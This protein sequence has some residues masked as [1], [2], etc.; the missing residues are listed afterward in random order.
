MR[1]PA[2]QIVNWMPDICVRDTWQKRP[3]QNALECASI[4]KHSS[5]GLTTATAGEI[6]KCSEGSLFDF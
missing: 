5:E 6:F 1:N 3:T 2:N 4:L